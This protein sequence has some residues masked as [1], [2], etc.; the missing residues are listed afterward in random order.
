MRTRVIICAGAM[1]TIAGAVSALAQ[2]TVAMSR[3][4]KS[5]AS[6]GSPGGQDDCKR[7]LTDRFVGQR[8]SP[9]VRSQLTRTVMHDRIRL[10]YAGVAVTS[11]YRPDRLNLIVDRQQTIMAIRCG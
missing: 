9:A 10:V 3:A 8:F 5:P 11:D 7:R 4:P 6:S 2:S 1:L